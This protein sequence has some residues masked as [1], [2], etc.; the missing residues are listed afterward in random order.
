MMAFWLWGA[1]VFYDRPGI[2]LPKSLGVKGR[3]VLTGQQALFPEMMGA[4]SIVPFGVDN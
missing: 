3:R 2:V 1:F 4:E